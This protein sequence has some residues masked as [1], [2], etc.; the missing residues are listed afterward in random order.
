MQRAKGTDRLLDIL[1]AMEALAE[2][3]SRNALAQMLGCPRSTIYA[4]VEQ[5]AERNWI[6]QTEDGGIRLGHRAGLMGLA[7][8]RQS[9][10]E[11]V[12]RNMVIDIAVAT[13]AVTEINV[14]ENWKQLVMISATSSGRNYLRTVE[15]SRY[16]LPMTGSARLQLVGVPRAQ[17]AARIPAEDLVLGSGQ[18]LDFEAFCNEIEQAGREGH[19]VA[20][21]LIEPYVA[22]LGAPI[23]NIAGECVATLS[24]VLPEPELVARRAELIAQLEQGAQ[25]LSEHLRAAPWPMGD[26]ARAALFATS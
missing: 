2:P 15:G 3:V 26:R 24:I 6:L 18:R 25:A 21:G 11:Q 8:A 14:I 13:G 17:L 1:E 23:K 16:P 7:Y 5:L 20:F 22:T 4:L 9:Q 19:F 10:F 12:A